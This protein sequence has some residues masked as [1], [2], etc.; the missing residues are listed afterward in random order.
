MEEG[1]DN[2]FTSGDSGPS[3]DIGNGERKSTGDGERIEGRINPAI[4]RGATLGDTASTTGEGTGDTP[5]AGKSEATPGPTGPGEPAK[6]GRGRP[7]KDGSTP[8][9]ASAKKAG[10]LK[11]DGTADILALAHELLAGLTNTPELRLDKAEY[12]ELG[13]AIEGVLEHGGIKIT[14]KQRA[15]LRLARVLSKIYVPTVTSIVV[16]KTAEAKRRKANLPPRPVATVTPI[17]PVETPPPRPNQTP[18]QPAFDP[19]HIELPD[20]A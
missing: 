8:A 17:R 14:P 12:E 10:D 1:N 19:F 3:G 16:R 11:I 18:G 5:G 6:R 4:A 9:P 20:G 13:D 15:Q 2:I 7:R